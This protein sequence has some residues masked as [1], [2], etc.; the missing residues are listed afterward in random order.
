MPSS[1]SS[2]A[3]TPSIRPTRLC[4]AWTRAGNSENWCW[5]FD[6]KG[7]GRPRRRRRK[8]GVTP[9]LLDGVLRALVIDQ[10]PAFAHARAGPS[11]EEVVG[12]VELGGDL[13]RAGAVDVAEAPGHA[14][15]REVL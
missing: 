8:T 5:R 13:H 3:S 4:A 14:H 11:L 2:T 10:E 15:H 7:A 1:P 6:G 9:A 12:L